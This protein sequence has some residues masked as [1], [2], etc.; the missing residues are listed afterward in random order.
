MGE[1]IGTVGAVIASLT[2]IWGV[3]QWRRQM[4]AGRKMQ[5]A[6]EVLSAFYEAQDI[7]RA[8]RSPMSIGDE[9]RTW[10][11]AELLREEPEQRQRVI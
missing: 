9:G 5:I 1:W 8:A 4:I 6:E 7:I 10:R 2:A 3:W 11:G